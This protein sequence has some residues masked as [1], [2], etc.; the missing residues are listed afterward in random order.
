MRRQLSI[1]LILPVITAC[2]LVGQKGNGGPSAPF[3]DSPKRGTVTSPPPQK[4]G[5]V[6]AAEAQQILARWDSAEREAMRQGG[7]DWSAAEAGLIAEIHQAE[8]R[9]DRLQGEAAQV[10]QSRIVKPRF[11]IP[12]AAAGTPW[13]LAEF[14]RP[15]NRLWEQIIFAKTSAGW[16]MV[17]DSATLDR[18]PTPARDDDGFATVLAPD[19]RAGLV[20]SPQELTRTHARLLTTA[21][22]DP[23]ANRIIL[24]NVFTW[25]ADVRKRDRENLPTGWDLRRNTQ[26]A[27]ES[28]A[29]RTTS[30][31]ALFWYGIT[32]EDTYTARTGAPGMKFYSGSLAKNLSKGKTFREKAVYKRASMYFAV[33]P[34]SKGK[35]KILWSRNGYLSVT[36]S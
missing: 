15:G 4:Q 5:V 7:T 32:E 28:Y 24:R 14:K 1:L 13:F 6:T 12:R 3:V 9:L 10:S 23:R 17:A 2:G 19:D 22:D 8:V 36:G 33:V 25:D 16:R 29:L 34:K 20:I 26:P 21:G 30:G 11:A 18:L 27:Q 35:V 31:S